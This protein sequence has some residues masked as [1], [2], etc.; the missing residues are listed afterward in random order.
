[1]IGIV[2]GVGPYAGLDL[3]KKIFDETAASNDQEHLP[4]VMI[5][6]SHKI[7]DRTSFLLDKTKTNP[8]FAIVEVIKKLVS[9]GATVVGIP[10][11]TAHS[12]HIFQVI[13]QQLRESATKVTLLHMV[14]E[15]A[16]YL[17]DKVAEVKKIGVL[18][19]TGTHK[20]K[21][22]PQIL[23]RFG[24]QAI[25]PDTTLQKQV[26]RAIYDPEFGIKTFSNPVNEKAKEI[27]ID[28]ISQLEQAGADI[29]VLGCT[30]LP[31]AITQRKIGNCPIIDPTRILAK[32]LIR[33][34]DPNK[35]FPF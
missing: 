29:V 3:M 16:R 31:L 33:A 26:H 27:L 2:G 30:E 24:L 21:I 35:L 10:C 7:A 19:T 17:T 14:E 8:A 20:T 34:V 25:L 12:P 18:S 1:M 15:T 22:Y 23:Q 4:V 9:V 11:N 5:S 6:E 32:A 28:A 13:K